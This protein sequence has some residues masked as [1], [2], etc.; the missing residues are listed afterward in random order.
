[1]DYRARVLKDDG[2][3]SGARAGPTAKTEKTPA[4]YH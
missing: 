3:G 4:S 1:M 2:I